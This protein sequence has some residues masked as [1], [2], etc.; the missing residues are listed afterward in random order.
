MTVHR[1]HCP[2][3]CED[4]WI[5]LPWL[6][7][8]ILITW[9]AL[10][11][12]SIFSTYVWTSFAVFLKKKHIWWTLHMKNYLISGR[13]SIVA[14]CIFFFLYVKNTFKM[15]ILWYKN[16]LENSF[17]GTSANRPRWHD[18][19]YLLASVKSISHIPLCGDGPQLGPFY[20]F[21]L[22]SKSLDYWYF[23]W[24]GGAGQ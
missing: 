12:A 13:Y 24:G 2:P 3:L 7:P 19:N 1:S 9:V 21:L 4:A 20:L 11:Y 8:N 17:I 16:D 10:T 18:P 23:M 6:D 14:C 22:A 15:N 5:T